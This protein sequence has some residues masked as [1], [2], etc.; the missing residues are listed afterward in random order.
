MELARRSGQKQGPLL[1]VKGSARPGV[2]FLGTG[3][4]EEQREEGGGVVTRVVLTRPAA[5]GVALKANLDLGSTC[6]LISHQ[7]DTNS[8]PRTWLW[9][10]LR[11]G[12][13]A[14]Q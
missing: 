13:S 7:V 3:T 4:T 14:V 12:L 5:R 1:H 2:N 10:L 11:M 6:H 8:S 9:A